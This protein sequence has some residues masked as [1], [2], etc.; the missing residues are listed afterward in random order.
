[1]LQVKKQAQNKIQ[2]S[3]VRY[4]GKEHIIE[5]LII[6]TFYLFLASTEKNSCFQWTGIINVYYF[7]QL[8]SWLLNI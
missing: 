8:N 5:L 2:A 3:Y 4:R 6:I 1:M 7:A